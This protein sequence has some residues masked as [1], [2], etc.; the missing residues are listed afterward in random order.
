MISI[1]V[2]E[3]LLNGNEKKYLF[4]CIETGWISS[5][6]PFVKQFEEQFAARVGRKYGIAVSNGSVALDAAIVAL[7][8][9]F[10]D[11]VILPTFTIISCAAA[12]VRAGAV[13]VVV[14]CDPQTWN[15]DVNQIEAKITSKTKAIMVVHIYGLPVDMEPVLALADK[16]GLHIIEDAAE[17]HGQ[18]YKSLP[19]GSFGAISTF[20][21]YPNKHI[22]TGEGGM[23]LTDDE[24]LAERCRSLR[25]L[26][27]QP[28]KR[29]VHEE[30]GWNLRM[31]NL[32]AALGVAQLERLDEF[33]ARKRHIGQ[34]YTEL[35]SD[36]SC[37]QLPIP[38][39][40]YAENIYWVYGLVLK[41]EVPFDAEEAMQ[42]LGKYKIGTRPFFWCM[43]EQPVFQKMGLFAG[44]SCPVAERIARRG[45]YIPSGMALT[46]EQA[47]R[48]CVALREILQ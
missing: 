12:I 7:E 28:Q 17:M 25:N 10:G 2:N 47:E 11:E 40:D 34:R 46:D 8:I 18:T 41:D 37:L 20:S 5:E 31:T 6:G 30:L 32:Q 45:F 29:F 9:G 23:L 13:P 26:C 27:F 15:I 44:E 4:E 43:H 39:T 1:P 38:Q 42:R 35:L 3:P 36:I 48:V 21:F 19:C 16:Y 14:D 24:R 22:T 33:I